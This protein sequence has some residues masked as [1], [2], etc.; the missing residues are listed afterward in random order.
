MK[1]PRFSLLSALER[2][3]A[4]IPALLLAHAAGAA[5]VNPAL[6][7]PNGEWCYLTKST[8]VIGV[9]SQPDVVQVTWDGSLYTGSAE[10]CF[11]YGNSN[12]PQAVIARQKT[13]LEGWIPIVQY[14]WQTNRIGYAVE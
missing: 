1:V 9:P 3:A 4:V 8:T 7:D 12:P 5:M 10:L 2:A 6:D 13:F 11:F 14:D